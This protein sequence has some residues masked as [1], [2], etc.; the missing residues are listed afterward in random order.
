MIGLLVGIAFLSCLFSTLTDVISTNLLF[1]S[2]GILKSEIL[3]VFKEKG[4]SKSFVCNFVEA[5]DCLGK[6]I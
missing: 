4:Q 1:F 6:R 3:D 5:L 2:I